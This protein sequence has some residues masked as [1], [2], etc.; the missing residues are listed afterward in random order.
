MTSTNP[1][2]EGD[3]GALAQSIISDCIGIIFQYY[4]CFRKLLPSPN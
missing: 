3:R 2:L 4:W 1:T